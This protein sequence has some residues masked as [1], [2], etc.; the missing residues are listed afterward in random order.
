MRIMGLDMGKKTIGIAVSDALGLIAQ[1]LKTLSRKT[2]EEDIDAL[3]KLIGE[4]EISEIV[5][6]L[7]KRTDGQLGQS[8]I[9]VLE[10]VEK[11][12]SAIGQPIHIWD[13]RFSTAAVTRILIEADVSRAKRRKVVNHLAAAYILQ[14]F[15][16]SR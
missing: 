12:R 3:K 7:P 4:L 11:L 15:L 14:G 1:P 10:F 16:D 5:V 2:E 13:E 8:E 6:G 9:V